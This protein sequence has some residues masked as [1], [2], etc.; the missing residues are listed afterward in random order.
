MNKPEPE[1]TPDSSP[2]RMPIAPSTA[3]E[4]GVWGE[5]DLLADPLRRAI[6]DR[7][8]DGP[9]HVNAIVQG[10]GVTQSAV[11]QQLKKMK[12]AGLVN[13]ERRGKYVLYSPCPKASQRL[14]RQLDLLRRR[15]GAEPERSAPPPERRDAIDANMEKWAKVWPQLDTIGL[16]T[17]LRIELI[18]ARTS[19][20][21]SAAAQ[22]FGMKSAEVRLLSGL[23]RAGPPFEAT[24]TE[25]SQIVL[26]SLPAVSKNVS[27]AEKNKFVER[28][29][30]AGDGR[31]SL[32][33]LTE[34]GRESLHNVLNFLAVYNMRGF[35]QLSPEQQQSLAQATRTLFA[36]TMRQPAAAEEPMPGG[37]R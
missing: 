32:L 1:N 35:R 24:L 14:L 28:R 17:F 6:F 36:V 29:A 4:G 33:R 26:R 16:S 10:V 30:N 11:S 31:S 19:E 2:R 12:L 27:N 5:L 18:N 25:L 7:L 13:E 22:K 8:I 21:M 15:L 37:T 3:E 9:L 20:A 34:H 23:E